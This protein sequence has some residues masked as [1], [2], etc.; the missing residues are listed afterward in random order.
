MCM[1]MI[2]FQ[3]PLV[4]HYTETMT[5]PASWV[6]MVD[7]YDRSAAIITMRRLTV[8]CVGS[9]LNSALKDI[10]SSV[11]LIVEFSIEDCL[12][13]QRVLN[14][15]LT[16][17]TDLFHYCRQD[18]HDSQR[19]ESV[20]VTLQD[21]VQVWLR[22]RE[23]VMFF[24]L[25]LGD[26]VDRWADGKG[27]LAVQLSSAELARLVVAVFEKTSRRDALVSQLQK[28]AAA[29]SASAKQ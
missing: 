20:E 9:L 29:A 16:G 18:E 21:C 19:H 28:N 27:P 26:V 14:V 25:G 5:S 12:C 13:L 17:S 24:G 1:S 8:M 7:V 6:C 10:I 11:L 22:F 3:L 4:E 2:F 23:L 15:L